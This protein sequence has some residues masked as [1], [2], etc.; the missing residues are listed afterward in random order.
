MP[1]PISKS[2]VRKLGD[3]LRDTDDPVD[4]DRALFAEVLGAYDEALSQTEDRLAGLG[5]SA[6][7][8]LKNSGTITEKLRR[9]RRLKLDSVQDLAGAR[10]VLPPSAGRP[11]Q[12]RT[13]DLL[14]ATFGADDVPRVTD[15]RLEP[16]HGYRALHIVVRVSDLPVEIQ[17]RT[18]MQH[19]WAQYFERLAD[20]IG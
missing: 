2:Q 1:L 17:I 20:Q 3:R 8:R 14:V 12:D 6:N 15:R 7:T 5:L 19:Q 16:S 18:T 11:E 9:D 10:I 4:E 13:R